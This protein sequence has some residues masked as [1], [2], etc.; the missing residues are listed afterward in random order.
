MYKRQVLYR[1]QALRNYDVNGTNGTFFLELHTPSAG[2]PVSVP[3]TW[4]RFK[5]DPGTGDAKTKTVALQNA[6]RIAGNRI[7]FVV[8]ADDLAQAG[9]RLG[10]GMVLSHW[11]ADVRGNLFVGDLPQWDQIEPDPAVAWPV[12]PA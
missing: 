12:C 8:T 11:A 5:T 3:G 10:G 1:V 4:L 7:T 2:D 9:E 6:A